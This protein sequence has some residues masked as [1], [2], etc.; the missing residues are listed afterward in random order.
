MNPSMQEHSL[1]ALPAPEL[2]ET[3]RMKLYKRES[4]WKPHIARGEVAVIDMD[5]NGFITSWSP[6]AE[7]I[8]GWDEV[9]VINKHASVLFS[10]CEIAH[11]KAAYEI[12]ATEH[13]GAFTS[14]SW[15]MRKNAQHFWSYSENQILF[16]RDGHPSGIRKLVVELNLNDMPT[17]TN[18]A[19]CRS[20]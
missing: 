10:N 20:E 1:R 14:F 17:Q 12:R 2:S 8:Y 11:G 6:T 5:L 19:C 16:G 13:K 18:T 15:Q 4:L 9:D 3:A 7:R